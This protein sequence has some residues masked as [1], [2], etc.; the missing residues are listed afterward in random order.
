MIIWMTFRLLINF[1]KD[2]MAVKSRDNIFDK[3]FKMLD[4]LRYVKREN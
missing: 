2:A 4:L 3:S 1:S